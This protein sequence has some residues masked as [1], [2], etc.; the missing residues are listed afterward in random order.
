M[1]ISTFFLDLRKA[2]LA[3]LDDLRSDSEGQ[4]VLHQRLTVKRQEI[5]FLVLMMEIS[6]EMV[7]VVFHRGFV[8]TNRAAMDQLLARDDSAFPSW[9][10]LAGSIELTPWAQDLA[11]VVLKASGGERFLT[12]TAGLEYMAGMPVAAGDVSA[13][14]DSDDED[15]G[16]DEDEDGNAIVFEGDGQGEEGEGS[17]NDRARQEAGADWLVQQGFDHK[18]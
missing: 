3:E 12:L 14:D 8:F 17:G 7:A 5:G 13:D 10:S 6:P 2:Y 4:D 1:T 16:D 18:D 9:D 15:A 11:D